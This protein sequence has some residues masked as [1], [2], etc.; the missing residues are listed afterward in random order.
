MTISWRRAPATAEDVLAGMRHHLEAGGV[1]QHPL[2]DTDPVLWHRTLATVALD[3]S[4]G[5]LDVRPDGPCGH[6]MMPDRVAAGGVP[7]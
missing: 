6:R 3:V 7:D 4:T 1:C 5:T 2:T